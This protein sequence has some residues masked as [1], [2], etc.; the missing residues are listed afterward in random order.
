M[1]N[2]ANMP[3]LEKG[4]AMNIP[5]VEGLPK[6]KGWRLMPLSSFARAEARQSEFF[7]VFAAVESARYSL[8]LEIAN[9]MIAAMIGV[10]IA[11]ARS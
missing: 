7:Y 5:E 6:P 3:L 8:D 1:L 4:F 10:R 9:W 11:N 2:N